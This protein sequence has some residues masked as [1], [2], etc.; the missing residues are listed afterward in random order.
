MPPS[1]STTPF[2][3]ALQGTLSGLPVG[4]ELTGTMRPEAALSGWRS[5]PEPLAGY[6]GLFRSLGLVL[7]D[8]SHAVH[9]VSER[10]LH[11]P[12]EAEWPSEVRWA[13]SRGAKRGPKS[14]RR[15]SWPHRP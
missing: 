7:L 9:S 2:D 8:L 3:L 1:P 10:D 15:S 12:G 5:Q 13:R 11:G 6:S 14:R 4:L